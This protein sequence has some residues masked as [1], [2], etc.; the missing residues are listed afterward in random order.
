MIVLRKIC[1][2]L[3]TTHAKRAIVSAT[4][5]KETIANKIEVSMI[6]KMNKIYFIVNQLCLLLM[7]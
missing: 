7:D 4:T 2:H 6:E 3:V 5:L 1:P